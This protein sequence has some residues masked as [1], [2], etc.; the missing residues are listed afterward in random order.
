MSKVFITDYVNCPTVE[1]KILGANLSSKFTS[2]LE[3]LLV[4]DK[5]IDKTIID[6]LPKLKAIIRYGAGYDNIDIN[7][8]S[9]KIF[10]CNVPDYG[11]DEVS[12]TTLA[13]ILNISRGISEYNSSLL[14]NLYRNWHGTY[15]KKIK[16]SSNITLGIV[17]SYRLQNIYDELR[18]HILL[19]DNIQYHR[20][21]WFI[22]LCLKSHNINLIYKMFYRILQY[23][24]S[25]R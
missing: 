6:S 16:R 14:S 10:V 20:V 18:A 3:V 24:I 21:F 13:M 22:F 12:D 4:W 15:K 1:K 7:Y 23:K 11:I 9:K 17:V 5:I 8:A 19:K 25:K 2:N